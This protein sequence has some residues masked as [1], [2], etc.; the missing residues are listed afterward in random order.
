MAQT[1][2]SKFLD[3]ALEHVDGNRR[4][5]LKRLLSGSAALA[6]LPLMTS[7]AVAQEGESGQGKGG[8]GGRRGGSGEAGF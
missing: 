3:Q 2:P 7:E 4:G 6:A 8:K 5:F 1:D